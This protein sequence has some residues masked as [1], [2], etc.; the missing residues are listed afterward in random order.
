MCAAPCAL[1]GSAH[2]Y[3]IDWTAASVVFS[4][5]GMVVTTR[6]VAIG[7]SM[8]LVASEYNVGGPVVSVDWMR[9]TPY[10]SSGTFL[11]RIFDAG[12][13]AGWLDLSW[14]ADLP[15]GT[16]V[17]M[18]VRTGDTPSPDGT[19]SDFTAIP[20]SG[21]AIGATSQYLQYQAALSTTD[22][23]QTPSLQDV[24][25]DYSPGLDQTP[26]TVQSV[27]PADGATDVAV[28]T[29][30]TAAFSEA[31]DA[32]TID[33]AT[34][35][36]TPDGGTPVDA[37][38]SYDPGT[39]TATLHPTADLAAGAGYT[40]SVT[41][42]VADPAGNHLEAAHTWAFTTGLASLSDTTVADFSAG[43]PGP[44][45]SVGN[46]AGGEVLLAPA[47][48]AE[49]SGTTLPA[50]WDSS[51][52]TPPNGTTTVAGGNLTVDG[53]QAGTTATYGPGHSL[54]FVGTFA[55]THFQHIGLAD[56]LFDSAFAMFSTNGTSDSLQ[57]RTSPGSNV[58]VCAAPCA[59]LGA[60]HRYRIDWT[61]S[62]VV[63][64]IDGSV[65]STQNTSIAASMRPVA[66][67][68]DNGGPVASVAWMH[69]T[70]YATSG[71]FLSRT[72]DAGARAGWRDLSWTADLP[73][74]TS[75]AMS[76]RAGD[77]SSPD[78]TWSAFQPVASPGDP[79]GAN[80]RYLQYRA[81]LS[82]TDV[83]Q[84]PSLQDVTL[85]FGQVTHNAPV[86]DSVV[87]DQASPKTGDTL[88][89]TVAAHDPDGDALTYAYQWFKGADPINGATDPTL[90]LSVVGNGDKGDSIGVRITA[91]DGDLSSAPVSS[92]QVTVANTP[93]EATV[94]LAPQAPKTAQIL[95]ATA[96]GSDPDGDEVTFTY[97][98]SVNSL[99]RPPGPRRRP[100]TPWTCPSRA[101]GT[102]D[103]PSP[104]CSPPTTGP[105]TGW[106]R[107]TRPLVA[108]SAP[109][110][111]GPGDQSSAEGDA[112][113]SR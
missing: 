63:F 82:T 1:I 62:Q 57:A 56:P 64:S 28:S 101:T 34:F 70:P 39:K 72:F 54:E 74:G 83:D 30:V 55:A 79:I 5:D 41:T 12:A 15:A 31:M 99:V 68:F 59:M 29:D 78:G 75:V 43:D 88:S 6:A 73:A 40:A 44:G 14:T 89:V 76:V 65:V 33:G 71:T 97:Q 47:V 51:Q 77:T 69:V 109:V 35:A 27:A 26:P 50:G 107:P 85:R 87:I 66:S 93:P 18:S 45:T 60:P 7:A 92:E 52:W 53:T 13:S 42:G 22:D 49:F 4:I 96:V 20:A 113:T 105:P 9:M 2:R 91:S 25:I 95:T 81:V 37:T 8:R 86:V 58:T 67:D 100:P 104:W 110:L 111:T 108:N 80:S 48:G 16:S 46:A 112:S 32:A 98:W 24:T 61:A 17:Q 23:G 106:E 94:T 10:A 102:R 38:V 11:S 36:L 84:T 19:W 21:G 90:D 3:R 103:T